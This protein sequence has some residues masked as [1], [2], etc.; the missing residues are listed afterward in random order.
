MTSA[1]IQLPHWVAWLQAL[2]PVFAVLASSFAVYVSVLTFRL[3]RQM[4]RWQESVAREKLR[5]D[6][7]N[8]RFE[9]F[10]SIFDFYEAMI[11]WQGTPAQIVARTRFFRAY[12]ESGFLFRKE[13]GIEEL[14]KRLN[15]DANKVIGFREHLE[16]YKA[17]TASYTKT[18]EEIGNIQTY[19]FENG[20]AQLKQAI[21][22][23]LY[24]P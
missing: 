23:Y 6:L 17:D 19:V 8:R 4:A 11:S 5:L 14:L 3:S 15:D 2:A 16:L 21:S 13:S 20:L 12:Q 10:S 1:T 7:Y 9:I 24:F 18:L 22:E